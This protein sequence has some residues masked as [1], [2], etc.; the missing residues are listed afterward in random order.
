MNYMHLDGITESDSRI[1]RALALIY[2]KNKCGGELSTETPPL[3]S[4]GG[5]AERGRACPFILFSNKTQPTAA[6]LHTLFNARLPELGSAPSFFIFLLATSPSR[7]G[8]C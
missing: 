7:C 1:Q 5:T 4:N 3:S 6:A 8:R 2:G